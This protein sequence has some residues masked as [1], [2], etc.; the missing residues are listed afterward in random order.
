MQLII[1]ETESV[2][3][4]FIT[5]MQLIILETE[6]VHHQNTFKFIGKCCGD[7]QLCPLQMTSHPVILAN[8]RMKSA[9]H[10]TISNVKTE[11]LFY[12]SL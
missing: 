5:K 10:H 9:Y 6:S 1:L 2:H 7:V 12:H 3:F 11:K 8:V 4:F